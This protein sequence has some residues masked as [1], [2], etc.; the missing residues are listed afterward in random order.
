MRPRLHRTTPYFVVGGAL[1]AGAVAVTT[2]TRYG[3]KA[4]SLHAYL[5]RE[6]LGELRS[7]TV[8][9]E[10]FLKALLLRSIM[11]KFKRPCGDRY[12]QA[13]KTGLTQAMLRTMASFRATYRTSTLVLPDPVKHHLDAVEAL[14]DEILNVFYCRKSALVTNQ[15]SAAFTARYI[16][17]GHIDRLQ[18]ATLGLSSVLTSAAG[19]AAFLK[20]MPLPA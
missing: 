6:Q 17:N 20:R 16:T 7:K 15:A 5:A 2:M 8:V 1:A 12:R 13:L 9:R 19:D 3:R 14:S 4:K 18:N 11:E 10:L